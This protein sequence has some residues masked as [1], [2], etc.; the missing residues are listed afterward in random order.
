MDLR[1]TC[2]VLKPFLPADKQEQF[3]ESYKI[4]I[5]AVNE[6]DVVRT[7][8]INISFES[9]VNPNSNSHPN[10]NPNPHRGPTPD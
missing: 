1:K 9:D 2:K 3:D 4:M 8:V 7:C 5:D 6:M 10:P